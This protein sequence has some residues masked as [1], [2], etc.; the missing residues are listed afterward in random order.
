MGT[1]FKSSDRGLDRVLL[2]FCLVVL[3]IS[4]VYPTARL[5]FSAFGQWRWAAVTQ[6]VGFQATIN[7][8]VMCVASVVLAGVTGTALAFLVTRYRFP[9]RT[10]LA[11]L[12]YLPFA[13]PPLVGTLSFYYLIGTDGFVPR[14][15]H[16]VLGFEDFAIA[17]PWAILLI[18]TYSFYVFFYA[19]VSAALEGMDVSQVEA[20]RTLGAGPW[21]AFRRVTLPMLSP[22][23]LGAALL[24]FMTSGASFSAP[25][26]FGNDFPYLSVQIF[27]ERSQ[28]HMAEALTL[29]VVLAC[30]SLAGVFV[31]RSRR[32][33]A[34]VTSKGAP[35]PVRSRSGRI[36]AGVFAWGF[37]T[38]ILTPHA[39]ITGLSFVDHREWYTELIPTV[40]TL[41]NY[42]SIFSD[43]AAFRP[44][45]NSLI[46]GA[47]A[48]LATL[49]V[50]LPAAYLIG[51][52]RT[53]A[54]WL[55][56]L[57]M[58]PWALPGTVIAMNLIAA[59]NDPWLPLYNTVLI[60]PVA[61]FV[62]NIPLL[63]RMA[64]A[65]ISQFDASLMEAGR[66]LGA[67]RMYCVRH[68]VLPLLAPALVAATALVFAT[69]LGEFVASILLYRPA[70][71][72]IAIQI[73]MEWRGSGV[74]S[75]F[76]YSVFLMILVTTTFLISRR[77]ASR[78]I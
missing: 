23:L 76:A 56:V 20:A 42:T 70:N 55:N 19:M 53:G 21:L 7:T 39:V 61:Y 43:P 16:E 34:G 46:M 27:K 47:V 57:V 13:L 68:I 38:L 45:R 73:N 78:I 75:A 25:L 18:H 52:G 40:F 36:V 49:A 60:L 41:E 26:F 3:G 31:F 10:P 1:P 44:I 77:L 30:I 74:G 58:I 71:L 48:A 65:S 15:A 63:T 17:G 11:G 5:A 32:K 12:A 62:R 22:A 64:T 28:F 24:T 4:I 69:C 33:A 8:V 6:G 29:T 67:S 14:F 35:R 9:G 50:G 59:F 2:V 51:R 54:R 37:I 66:T 72:P